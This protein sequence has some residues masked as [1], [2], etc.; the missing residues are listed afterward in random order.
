MKNMKRIWPVLAVIII[1]PMLASCIRLGHG[2]VSIYSPEQSPTSAPAPE[3]SPS[4][5]PSP[6]PAQT[7]QGTYANRPI[8]DNT[9]RPRYDI[10]LVFDETDHS[11]AAS[12]TVVYTNTSA[13]SMSELYMHI[14]PNHFSR[15]AYVD[16]SFMETPNY[17]DD[18]FNPGSIEI[19]S[20]KAAGDPVK[21]KVQGEEDTILMIPLD[22]PLPKGS[23]IELSLEYS[24]KVPHRI[25]RYAW[26]D[27]GTSFGNWY[28]IMAVYDDEGWNL[29]KYYELG[30]PFYS[31]TGD[32]S[33]TIDMPEGMQAAFTG[34]IL[35]D[36]I[37]D[38]RRVL[39]LSETG[40]R[41]FA[42]VL[43]RDYVIG[44]DT[45]DGIEVRVAI[46]KKYKEFLDDVMGYAENSLTLYNDRFGRYTNDTFT[47]AFSDFDSGMEYPGIVLISADYFERE[48]GGLPLIE[49]VVVHE[50][51]HQWWYSAVGNDEVDEAWLDE[52]LTSFTEL[53]YYS[54]YYGRD[55]IA[56]YTQEE[57]IEGMPLDS[58]LTAFSGWDD[59]MY[60]YSFGQSF[61]KT[62]MDKMGKDEFYAMLRKYYAVYAYEIA[63][64]DDLRA[65]VAETGNQDALEWYDECVY[66]K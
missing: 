48:D 32:Y 46:P 65:L 22:G 54:E 30:D 53:V 33:V 41:D 27:V 66:G 47:V 8:Y 56:F 4:P 28:P 12:Q 19:K 2:P 57:P 17:P 58:S 38:G 6:S 23:S 43:S 51:G 26:G 52:G 31:E 50:T 9:D 55:I 24:L 15:K 21:F 40:V 1:V 34:D 42:F 63:T 35:N 10:Q 64:A 29:D 25:G 45:V 62:L 39:S 37:A 5:V 14:Y 11:A 36:T 44:A 13:E 60:V 3:L 16:M 61:F 49:R 20:V 18:K 7:L 59:Y